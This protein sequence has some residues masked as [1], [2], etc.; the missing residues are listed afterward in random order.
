MALY[1]SVDRAMKMKMSDK[2]KGGANIPV[3]TMCSI[4]PLLWITQIYSNQSHNLQLR[5]AK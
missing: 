1:T 3:L 4:T 5:I 2:E